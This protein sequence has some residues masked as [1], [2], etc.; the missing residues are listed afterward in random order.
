M[1]VAI[2]LKIVERMHHHTFLRLIWSRVDEDGSGSL[3][4]KEVRSLL[5]RMGVDS[6]MP[7]DE[8]EAHLVNMA[9]HDKD[10]ESVVCIH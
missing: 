1:L 2:V 8:L 9:S 5:S 6:C 3:D 7:Q 10:G 4:Q